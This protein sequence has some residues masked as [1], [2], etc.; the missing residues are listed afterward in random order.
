MIEIVTVKELPNDCIAITFEK[1][2]KLE[3]WFKY[4]ENL[5]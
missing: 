5:K 1:I 3:E 4:L 2:W